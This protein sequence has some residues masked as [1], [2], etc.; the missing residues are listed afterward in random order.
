MVDSQHEPSERVAD[1]AF[2][3]WPTG[4]DPVLAAWMLALGL[5]PGSGPVDAAKGTAPAR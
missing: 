4:D 1:S 5:G 2:D 3:T